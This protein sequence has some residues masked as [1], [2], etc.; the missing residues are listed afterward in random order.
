MNKGTRAVTEEEYVEI[1]QTIRNGFLTHKP[2]KKVAMALI[3][4]ANIGVRISD[5]V[6]FCLNDIV[7]DGDRYILDIVE[8]KTQKER[9][10]IVP[11]ELVQ[12]IRQ[13]C[14]DNNIK[15]NERIIPLTERAIQKH[16]LAVCEYLGLKDISTHSFRKF[17]SEKL[18]YDN[19][20]DIM[21]VMEALQHSNL[22]ST[23]RYLKVSSKRLEKALLNNLHIV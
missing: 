18:Y 5:I 10:F 9:H 1:I 20:E 22:S 11:Y 2:N 8:Q 7:K 16:L 15:S 17:F 6:Q 14:I 3:L 12:F 19:E 4:E 23:Q 21:L 13:Y